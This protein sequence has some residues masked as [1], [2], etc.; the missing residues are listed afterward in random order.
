M[1]NIQTYKALDYNNNMFVYTNNTNLTYQPEASYNRFWLINEELDHLEHVP[2]SWDSAIVK[3]KVI[4]ITNLQYCSEEGNAYTV[5]YLYQSDYDSIQGFYLCDYDQVLD[6]HVLHSIQELPGG[7]I[8]IS[9]TFASDIVYY[10]YSNEELNPKLVYEDFC[11][12]IF[13]RQRYNCS[14][15]NYVQLLID[16]LCDSDC[17]MQESHNKDDLELDKLRHV[18]PLAAA[19]GSTNINTVHVK[20]QEHET[21]PLGE[22][23]SASQGKVYDF[24]DNSRD[25]GFLPQAST[26]FE[27]IG[28]DRPSIL[29]DTVDKYIEIANIILDTGLPNYKQAHIPLQSGLNI[30]VWEE[31][32]RDYPNKRLL[33][34]LK[35]G[36]PLSLHNPSALSNATI[37]NHAS[38]IKHF[39]AVS[40]YITKECELG[41]ILG[42]VDSIGHHHYHCSPL[43]TRPKDVDKSRVILNL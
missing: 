21:K 32:L 25:I 12:D 24:N 3:N 29:I 38:A 20:L 16:K 36:Y 19:G 35:F 7:C 28:P 6:R 22:A 30:E 11:K 10:C 1:N 13:T 17:S 15:T 23:K 5:A 41:A 40:Q 42:P 39:T 37:S 9:Y 18:Y 8:E 2:C 26:D 43:L 31:Y 14:Y 4:G 33:Q 27:F 34:Y